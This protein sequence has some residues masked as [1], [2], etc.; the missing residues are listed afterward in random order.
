MTFS[1]TLPPSFTLS[2]ILPVSRVRSQ[3]TQRA[4]RD[5]ELR[6]LLAATVRGDERAFHR[7]YDRTWPLLLHVAQGLLYD[8]EVACEI[9][10]ECYVRIWQ[11]AGT[12]DAARARPLTWMVT[13]VRNRA[14]DHLRVSREAR[15][16]YE[17]PDDVAPDEA[18]TPEEAVGAM[19]DGAKA[20]R[21]LDSLAPHESRC[22]RLAYLHGY[23]H[24]EIADLMDQPLGTIK[25]WIRRSL[26]K[27]RQIS[28]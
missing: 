25:S 20:V 2:G 8:R 28:E 7:L 3:S 19:L 6:V 9:L 15:L 18:P 14:I 27:L 17:L 16:T 22:L 23:R 24:E 11:S 13:I 5:E 12:Y 21:M 10:Q 4:A 26:I 1:S